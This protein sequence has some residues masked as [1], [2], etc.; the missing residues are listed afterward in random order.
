MRRTD[1]NASEYN[2]QEKFVE[3]LQKYKWTAPD[4]LNGNTGK[5][6]V[7]DLVRHWRG[8]LN[9]IN[10]DQLEGVPLTDNEFKQVMSRVN[11][12]ENSY[13]ASKLLAME[14][15]KGKIDG[16]HRDSLPGVTREQITLTIFKKAAV[17]GGD[18]SY[19][20]A[21]EVESAQ[22]NRFDL[23]LLINGLPLINIEQ[24]RSDQ[25][26]DAAFRQFKRYYQ[27]GEYTHNFL[28]FSQMMVMTSEVA[29]RYFATPKTVHD[30]ND[31]FVF[32]WADSNNTP[33]NHW[34][35]IIS[36]FLRIPMAHQMVGDY[37]VIDEALD[38]E[39][40]RHMLMRPYQVHALQ[41]VERAAFGVS[42]E[43]KFPHG[44]FVWHTTGSGKTITSF[45]TALFLSTRGGFDKVVFLVDRR[46]L[47][48]RTSDN[49]KAYAAYEPVTVDDT[50]HTYQ[51]KKI[52]KSPNRGIVV[53]TT[54]KLSNLVDDLEDNQDDGLKDKKIIFIIDEAHRTTMGRMMGTIKEHFR[55]KGLFFGYTGTPLYQENK[56]KGMFDKNSEVIDTTE[57]LFGPELHKYTIDEAISDGNVLGFHVDY[58]NTGEFKSYEDLKE[59]I[60]EDEKQAFPDK[61]DKVVERLVYSWGDLEVENQASKRKLLE[62]HDD[63]HIPR[64]VEEIIE[65]WES[66]SQKRKFNAILTVAY[67]KRVLAYFEEFKK[68]LAEQDAPFN[69]A[70]TFSFG[71]DED[72]E[73]VDTKV[74]ED[75]FKNYAA[76]TGIEFV[77]GDKKQGPDAYFEDLITRATRGGSGRHPKNIDLII[78]AD[79]L[80]TGY[81]AQLLNTLYVDRSLEL[82]GLVQAYSRTN[83]VHGPDKEFG[84]IINFQYPKISEEK[85]DNALKLYGT[86]G[87]SSKV[88]IEPYDTAVEQLNIKMEEM[89]LIMPDPTSWQEI[90]NDIVKKETFL[91]SFKDADKH[92]RSVEQY[93][94]F[95][96]DNDKFGIDKKTWLNYI[97]AYRNLCTQE[98]EDSEI[99]LIPTSLPGKTRLVGT[100]VIDASHILELMGEQATVTNGKQTVDAE[101]L[102]IVYQQIEELSN[103]GNHEKAQL[104]KEFVET[105]LKPGHVS[106]EIR[107]DEAFENWKKGKKRAVIYELSK[108]WGI[109]SQIFEKSVAAY[110]N[111]NPEHIPYIVDLT[112]TL[113][114]SS[115]TNPMGQ[116]R[117]EHNMKLMNE[118]PK[119]IPKINDKYN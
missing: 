7:D 97:G 75:M 72:P 90:Q 45:K 113:D 43:D 58:I 115:A 92:M 25:T 37:L 68:Q 18:S 22:G 24:K 106:T 31:S 59:A 103:L 11:Q 44:G 34:E 32:H 62:Y 4:L 57:K 10:A 98:G 65:N 71:G 109:N 107:F 108:E 14:A 81:D 49:F 104:L 40:R 102:R 50:Q 55:E 5:V 114:F 82:H 12:L 66:Q 79:Q 101:T 95:E 30:F 46:E 27:D 26:L 89:K 74:V 39:N 9:R 99:P 119:M 105:E 41:S 48:R 91:L 87:T 88:I 93:Y 38:R 76:F 111:Q 63:T 83:R 80:L 52:M 61:S 84:S 29:T 20:I 96:W 1:K 51:L 56:A 78:V 2:F 60:I 85:V 117:L 94:Q 8:E 77:A 6:T 54:Y 70:M 16:I 23:I 28:A 116:N 33:V 42:T 69:V 17:S 19:K 110:S 3:E 73:P 15:S 36:Q 100:Q 112:R 35:D 86:G 21:R 53:T 118:L 13:E 47:D 67:K 64:V